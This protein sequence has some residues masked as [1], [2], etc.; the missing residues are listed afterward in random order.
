MSAAVA[1]IQYAL[2]TDDMFEFLNY[3]NEGEFDKLREN[4]DDIPEEV[5]IGADPLHPG[6]KAL[7]AK[8]DASAIPKYTLNLLRSASDWLTTRAHWASFANHGHLMKDYGES[9]AALRERILV[10]VEVCSHCGGIE[11]APLG[12]EVGFMECPKCC[13]D[14]MPAKS[15]KEDD[16]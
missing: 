11:G 14:L 5:F 16:E 7:M 6:T 3:W 8:E 10:G 9:L 13:V 2:Q 4:W 12:R 15:V 1:A